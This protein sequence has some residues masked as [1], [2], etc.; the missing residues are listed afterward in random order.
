MSMGRAWMFGSGGGTKEGEGEEP[1]LLECSLCF[2]VAP[3]RA[4]MMREGTVKASPT[5]FGASNFYGV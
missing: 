2:C 5:S 4:W 3:S 1:I